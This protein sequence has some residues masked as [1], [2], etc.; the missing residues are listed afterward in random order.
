[1]NLALLGTIAWF[2]V[3]IGGIDSGLYGL[4]QFHLL[5]VF[6]GSHFFGRIF[7]VLIGVSAGYLIYDK[8]FA[9]KI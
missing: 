2:L 1:M 8:Y 5:E 3:V 9:K 6:L 4:F 7:F